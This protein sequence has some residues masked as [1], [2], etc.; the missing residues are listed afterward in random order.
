MPEQNKKL[1]SAVAVDKKQEV[2]FKTE[3]PE[4]K[5]LPSELQKRNS[6]LFRNMMGHLNKAKTVLEKQKD[7]V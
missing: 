7:L 4:I 5:A 3:K 1:G 2:E 6:N